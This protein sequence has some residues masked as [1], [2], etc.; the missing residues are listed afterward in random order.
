MYQVFLTKQ[1]VK[2]SKRRG[3]KFKK[4]VGAISQTLAQDPHP[5]ASEQLS[6]EL[7]HIWSYHFNFSGSAYRLAYLIDGKLKSITILMLGPR[8]NFYKSLRQKFG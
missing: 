5:I 8:E 6:G 2:E 1:V 4:I 7:R 3:S